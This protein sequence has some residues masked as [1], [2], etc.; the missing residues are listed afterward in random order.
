MKPPPSKVVVLHNPV[1]VEMMMY[2]SIYTVVKVDGTT[3]L[4]KGGFFVRDHDNPR[5]MGVA[6]HLLSSW[7]IIFL[8]SCEPRQK[9]SDTFHEI[10]V[11]SW[12]SLYPQNWLVFHPLYTLNNQGFFVAHVCT[13]RYSQNE[14]PSHFLRWTTIVTSDVS[15]DLSRRSF[16]WN[17]WFQGISKIC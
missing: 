3:T 4:P 2:I 10:P 15:R 1:P 9:S 6:D 5:L 11:V 12:G 8:K 13:P 16:S 17:G 14:F 7:K